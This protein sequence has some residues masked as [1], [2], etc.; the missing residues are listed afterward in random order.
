MGNTTNQ[1]PVATRCVTLAN[2][3]LCG[4][5]FIA[6]FYSKDI[7]M[8]AAINTPNN[9]IILIIRIFSLGLTSFYSIRFSLTTIWGPSL[10]SPWLHL[11]EEKNII[12]PMLFLSIISITCGRLISWFPPIRSSFYILP[13]YLKFTPLIIITLGVLVAYYMTTYIGPAPAHLAKWTLR[14]Y[15]LCSIW[16]LVPI[17]SQFILKWPISAAHLNI[18]YIDHGWLESLSGLKSNEILVNINNSISSYS[19]KTPILY[20]STFIIIAITTIRLI[21]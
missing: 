9:V 5:P 2:L 12:T 20:L 17:S 16:F 14:H 15:A 10:I 4:F 6:G 21:F 11:S 3:A 13:S 7:I 18:K 8:E 19:S 1:I